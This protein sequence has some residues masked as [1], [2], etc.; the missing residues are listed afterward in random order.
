MGNGNSRVITANSFILGNG[1][2]RTKDKDKLEKLKLF[3]LVYGCNRIYS[4]F[5]C[6][7][8]VAVD[9]MM[10]REIKASGY[11]GEFIYRK[12]VNH[13]RSLIVEGTNIVYED[14]GWASGP[15]AVKILCERYYH[16][17][18]NT[19]TPIMKNVWFIGFDLYSNAGGLVNN[20]YKNSQY[21]LKSSDPA[22]P[23]SHWIE[24]LEQVF[25]KY[26]R[27]NFYRVGN[28]KDEF[29]NTWKDL[30]NIKFIDYREMARILGEYVKC[31]TIID[32]GKGEDKIT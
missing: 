18:D 19:G 13:Q 2:S 9:E 10:I 32:S 24:Q 16:S 31:I 26:P 27:V 15:S 5:Q 8:L 1:E 28:I 22:P 29:P 30:T 21:Y 6:D 12:L 23:A 20:L 4:E 11:S 3:G 7:L 14:K 25:S 17:I